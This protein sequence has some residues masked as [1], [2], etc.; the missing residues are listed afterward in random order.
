MTS[1]QAL[2]KNQ[3]LPKGYIY[4]PMDSL[5]NGKQVTRDSVERKEQDGQGEEFSGLYL[6]G[7]TCPLMLLQLQLFEHECQIDAMTK[8]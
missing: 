6:S 2:M 8:V 3:R 4:V 5:S 1:D 7:F